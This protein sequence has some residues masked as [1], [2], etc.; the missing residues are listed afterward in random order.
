MKSIL[1]Q[2]GITISEKNR[3]E[4]IKLLNTTLAS[5]SDLYAQLK[6][7]H[8]NI[9]GIEFIALH[10]LF[11]ELADHVLEQVDTVAERITALGGTALGTLDQAVKNS[12]LKSYPIDIFTAK[13]HLT[14]LSRNM[15]IL[16][17][18]CRQ[19]IKET[20][21]TDMATSDLYIEMTRQLDKDLWFLQAHLQK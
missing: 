10:K 2:T 18:N 19:L 21:K 12:E 11:D 17:N 16:A 8:W 15:A 9:K 20:E 14:H 1:H 7:A 6:Q 5:T 3:V 4:L 13:E